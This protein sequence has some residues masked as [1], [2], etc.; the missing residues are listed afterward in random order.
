[1]IAIILVFYFTQLARASA[2]PAAIREKSIPTDELTEVA[3]S[4][5][6]RSDDGNLSVTIR[7]G[8]A[9]DSRVGL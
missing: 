5:V 2:M 6:A 7:V 1:M 9:A 3:I 4:A 8:N